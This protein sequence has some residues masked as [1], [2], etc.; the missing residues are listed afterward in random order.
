MP[1]PTLSKIETNVQGWATA[2]LMIAA[3][4]AF[5]VG[6]LVGIIVA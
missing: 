6:V 3:L 1:R 4:I 2:H 5:A